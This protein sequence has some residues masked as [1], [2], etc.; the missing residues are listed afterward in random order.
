MMRLPKDVEDLLPPI[1]ATLFLPDPAPRPVNP[2][3]SFPE[4][5]AMLEKR[6]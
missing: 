2:S 6:E 4:I 3:E 5:A 1:L